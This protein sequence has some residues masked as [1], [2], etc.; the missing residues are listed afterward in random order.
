MSRDSCPA[1]CD[2]VAW[3]VE[4]EGMRESL[5]FPWVFLHFP[6]LRRARSSESSGGCSAFCFADVFQWTFRLGTRSWPTPT[7]TLDRSI[8][9]SRR[10]FQSTVDRGKLFDADAP[11]KTLSHDFI[12]N[13]PLV[14][15]WR[16][17]RAVRVKVESW[18]WRYILKAKRIIVKS[19]KWK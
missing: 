12:S 17:N 1:T 7:S 11:A 19:E 10:A 3:K 16:K 18:S 13:R 5:E 8:P 4:M 14:M 6:L 9:S 2:M 15:W